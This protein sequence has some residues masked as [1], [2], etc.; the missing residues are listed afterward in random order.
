MILFKGK[1]PDFVATCKRA[2]VLGN[3][4][5][6]A[7]QVEKKPS[8]ISRHWS[9][10]LDCFLKVNIGAAR[11]G[12]GKW[13]IGVA[14]RNWKGK[15]V[16]AGAKSLLSMEDP[17]MAECLALRW[18][19]DLICE[20]EHTKIILESDCL[21]VCDEF[22]NSN[23]RS[24]IHDLLEDIRVLVDGLDD[25]SLCFAPRNCNLVAHNLAK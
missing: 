13:G 10:P 18:A 17:A 14:G 22:L 20:S 3:D 24:Q 16:L 25:F 8:I 23:P 4:Y 12:Y 7:C 1:K 9:P 2:I 6:T 15:L 21:R 11:L 19:M 5:R